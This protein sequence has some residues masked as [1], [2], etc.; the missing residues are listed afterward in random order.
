M[1]ELVRKGN[2]KT[3]SQVDAET[4]DEETGAGFDGTAIWWME[5]QQEEWTQWVPPEVVEKVKAALENL[6]AG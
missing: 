3:S 1:I 4:Y 6:R 2:F 5:D